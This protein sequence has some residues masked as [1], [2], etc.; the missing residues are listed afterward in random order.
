MVQV[1]HVSARKVPAHPFP[2]ACL[3]GKV[4]KWEPAELTVLL[5]SPDFHIPSAQGPVRSTKF[6]YII[7]V[8]PCSLSSLSPS[9]L[10]FFLLRTHCTR[11]V[12]SRETGVGTQSSPLPA[13]QP[14]QALYLPSSDGS[15]PDP[16]ACPIPAILTG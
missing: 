5:P 8:W 16:G 2:W 7:F 13:V 1:A 11:K 3:S 4:G 14:W 10:L 12:W 9:T 15:Q 6:F